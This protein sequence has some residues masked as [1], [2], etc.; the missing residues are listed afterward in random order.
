MAPT[1]NRSLLPIIIFSVV[2]IVYFT[3]RTPA[4]SRHPIPTSNAVENDQWDITNYVAPDDSALDKATPPGRPKLFDSIPTS[5]ELWRVL[6]PNVRW[7]LRQPIPSH[8]DS[9]ETQNRYCAGTEKQANLDQLAGDG[10]WW[11]KATNKE[12][13]DGRRR[14]AQNVAERFGFGLEETGERKSRFGEREWKA[15]FGDGR[16]G[17]VFTAGN[18]DTI[19]R[20]LT[21][22][23][24]LRR[25]GCRLPAEIWGFP[26]EIRGLSSSKK[27]EFESLG[28]IRFKEVDQQRRA[29]QWKQFQIKGEAIAR[30]TFSEVLYLDSDNIAIRD[31]TFLFETP[32]YKRQGVVLWPDLTKDSPANAIFR[33]LS[34]TCDP[35]EWQLDSGQILISKTA[36]SGLNLAALFV[37]EAM[38]KDSE[39]WFKMSGGDKDTFRYAFHFLSLD[40]TPAPHWLSLAGTI[41]PTFHGH[42]FCG[43]TMVQ[44]GFSVQ[45]WNSIRDLF[46]ADYTP[47][48]NHAPPLFLH[49]NLLKHSGSH[50]A[51]GQVW[52]TFKSA[53]PDR[54][55]NPGSELLTRHIRG[56]VYNHRGMCSDLWDAEG[57]AREGTGVPWGGAF[58][59]GRFAMWDFQETQG[60]LMR[61]IEKIYFE[62]GG[63][64]G[65]SAVSLA[66]NRDPVDLSD[67]PDTSPTLRS[68]RLSS[69]TPPLGSTAVMFPSST[70]AYRDIYEDQDSLIKSQSGGGG[71]SAKIPWVNAVNNLRRPAIF[72][73]LASTVILL[74]L[75]FQRSSSN[76]EA[77]T[78]YI[79]L[80]DSLHSSFDS[81]T[82]TF[83]GKADLGSG[84]WGCNP[85]EAKGRLIVDLKV[86][87]NNR[88]VPYDTTCKPSTYMESLYRGPNDDGPLIPPKTPV[89]QAEEIGADG[90]P[91]RHVGR[92]F[93]PWFMNRTLVIH[94][95]SI[96]RFHLK[97]FCH[98][99]KGNLFV[100]SPDH[101]ASPPPY[102]QTPVV[103]IAENGEETPESKARNDARREQERVWE[104]RPKDGIDLT[105][106]WVCDIEE[107]GTTVVSVFTWGLE[108]AEDYYGIERW[109]NPPAAW[110]ERLDHITVPLLKRLAKYLNRPKIVKPDLV[111]LNSGFWDLRKYTE[112]DFIAAGW[113]SRPYPED[114]D[115]PYNN[116]SPEREAQWERDARKAIKKAARAW[117]GPEDDARDGPTILWRTLHHPRRHNYAPYPRVHQLDS[118]ALK[119][120]SDLESE[121]T[122]FHPGDRYHSHSD[123]GSNEDLGLDE[124][125]RIDYSGHL[126]A[127][128]DLHFRDLLHPNALPGS[129]LWGNVMLYEL[130]RAT[131]KIGR[132]AM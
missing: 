131:M 110:G 78:S 14:V 111:E 107:Y 76:N 28:D 60:G 32:L 94:G 77:L 108:G 30:S 122:N 87:T 36:R 68:R 42:Q 91:V 11:E 29:G 106:P 116:L 35:E 127:G 6:I 37:A 18:K 25:H 61:N 129:W 117:R 95:D 105:N 33:T 84:E 90:R 83:K 64:T 101:A 47:R 13:A 17:L 34:Y 97:D 45:E 48:N 1:P 82:S 23:K 89:E 49:A 2:T 125:L 104:A 132:S 93:L 39:F 114:S 128:Q 73:P 121:Y 103:E 62:E 3:F 46:D 123:E 19:N 119:V 4:H 26:D 102:H 58:E 70:A 109:Y 100:V 120:V 50:N 53:D 118:L 69:A 98:F 51:P 27:K 130:K 124:R 126:M 63:V 56:R 55:R 8:R 115:I 38:Q 52:E 99:L 113:K 79:P 85:F 10:Q 21:S 74:I 20:L 22:L 57:A 5:T 71:R 40:F 12:L 43:H 66:E 96:D 7:L 88:W 112:Q 54:I 72:V 75:I 15:L 16:K 65:A 41:I 67:S 92:E 80:A 44:F 86:P 81:L 9:L 31:P 59:T 24:V